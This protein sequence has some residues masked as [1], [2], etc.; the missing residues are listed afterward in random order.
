M[1]APL[2]A[3]DARRAAHNFSAAATRY[4]HAAQLQATTRAHLLERLDALA[5]RPRRIVDLGCGTGLAVPMLQQRHAGA[6][7]IGLDRAPGMMAVARAARLRDGVVA[8]AQALPFAPG[9][10]DLLYSNLALQW[11]PQPQA[12]LAEAARALR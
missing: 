3:L 8:D 5:L 1:S 4:E 2:V 6:F 10:V 11:C 12:A 9:S 7:V